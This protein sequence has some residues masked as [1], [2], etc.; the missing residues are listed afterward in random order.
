VGSQNLVAGAGGGIPGYPAVS[1]SLLAARLGAPNR[2]VGVIVAVITGLVLV[3][4]DLV[5]NLVP[6]PLLGSLL[7]W[8][9]AAVT[10]EWL[11]LTA[12]R[13]ELWGYLIVVLIFLVIVLVS[14]TTGIL[15]GLVAAIIL[16]V[17]EYGN[18]DSIRH[19]LTGQDYQST[20]EV[21]EERHESLR[22]HGGAILI[23]RLQ[24]FIFFGTS[25]RLRRTIEDRLS[26]SVRFLIIDFGRVTRVDSSAVVSFIRLGQIAERRGFTMVITGMKEPVKRALTRSGL[27]VGA[28]LRL[29]PDFDDGLVWCENRLLA[30][31]APTL[32]AER[33]RGRA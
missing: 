13:L 29:D 28:H 19:V 12:R 27:K 9:G 5:L 18:L 7:L 16:F 8:I 21:S 25:D 33:P 3:L 10:F 31:L 17:V 26:E 23:V 30:K 2:F 22:L 11:V 15:V 20:Y 32:D 6:T 14:F 24:G 1:L 4:G